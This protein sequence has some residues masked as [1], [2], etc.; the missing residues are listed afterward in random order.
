MKHISLVTLFFV[1]IFAAGA[2][3]FSEL[4][5]KISTLPA[6]QKTKLLDAYFDGSH[7]VPVIENNS[8]YFIYKGTASTV[9]IAG[10]ATGWS[11]SLK[12]QKIGGTDYWYASAQYEADARLEYKI[13][14]DGDNWLLDPLNRNIAD[15]G[16]GQNSELLMPAYRKS[17]VINERESTPWSLVI[18]TVLYSKCLKEER[19]VRICIPA[20]YYQSS[21]LYPV[22][23]FHDGFEYYQRMSARHVIDNLIFEQKIKPLIAVYVKPMKRDLEYSGK[24]QAAYTNFIT[25][26]LIN[27]MD[28]GFR[29]LKSPENR[30][31]AGI[32]NGGNIALWILASNPGIIGKAGAQ[33][34]NVEKNVLRVFS[35]KDFSKSKIYIDFGKYDLPVLVPLVHELKQILE[36][37]QIP[38]TYIEFPEGHNWK[39]W[40]KQ[41][42]LMLEY[43]FPAE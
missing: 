17:S 19:P 7:A 6:G 36:K 11:P 20:D 21:V 14:V 27:F 1:G 30:A 8:V 32:S 2:Q 37:R 43:L 35:K 42:P 22:I 39:A 28:A 5:E 26:E 4:L 40:Q 23:I 25:Q 16:M 3:N 15:G 29:T 24:L 38:H 34:S 9:S 18:D 12:M 13:V 41:L 31:T 10:D 33:S